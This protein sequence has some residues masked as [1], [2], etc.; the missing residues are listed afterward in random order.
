MLITL[1][2]SYYFNFALSSYFSDTRNEESLIDEV[3]SYPSI[4]KDEL[5]HDLQNTLRGKKLKFIVVDHTAINIETLQFIILLR[6]FYPLA[7]LFII[8][9]PNV[10]FDELVRLY[11]TILDAKICLSLSEIFISI[12]D[13]HAHSIPPADK[14]YLA[15]TLKFG[16]TKEEASVIC[17]MMS[18]SPL[19]QIAKNQKCELNKIYYHCAR[20]RNKMQAKDNNT[21]VKL[22]HSELL[23]Y[24]ITYKEY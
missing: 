6:T 21:L 17:L 12:N 9:K 22:I 16:I 24:Y 4:A 3:C 1:S 14:I 5:M 15:T 23:S 2:N 10:V 11:I 8:K 19:S 20:A 18:G 7:R 13:V